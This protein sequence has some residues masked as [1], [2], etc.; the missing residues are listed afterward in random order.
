M[1]SFARQQRTAHRKRYA[2]STGV[3]RLGISDPAKTISTDNFAIS[4][5]R[6]DDC[7]VRQAHPPPHGI[8]SAAGI[9]KDSRSAIA[10]DRPR[11]ADGTSPAER[12]ARRIPKPDRAECAGAQAYS[13]VCL[14]SPHLLASHSRAAPAIRF[15][16][17]T[18]NFKHSCSASIAVRQ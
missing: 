15:V 3:F 17:L 10:C 6:P 1:P 7:A 14:D 8:P 13:S 9:E 16:A 12:P 18:Q 2:D 5:R 11:S 4:D